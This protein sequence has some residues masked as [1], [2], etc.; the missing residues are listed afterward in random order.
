MF[1]ILLFF[2]TK[3]NRYSPGSFT[4]SNQTKIVKCVHPASFLVIFVN[5]TWFR[6]KRQL[7]A[8]QEIKQK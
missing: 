1:G 6:T 8:I 7:A 3:V 2:T 4:I 5:S